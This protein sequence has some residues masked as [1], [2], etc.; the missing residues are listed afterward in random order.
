MSNII[1]A[2]IAVVNDSNHMLV[3][4]SGAHNRINQTGVALE[5]YIIDLFA[6][7]VGE[8]NDIIR[9]KKVSETFSYIGN[10]NNPPDSM[11]KGGGA[12]IEVKKIESSNSNLAL[13]SSYPKAKLYHDSTMI[14]KHCKNCEYWTIR[15]IIYAVGVVKNNIISSIAFVY[16]EDMCADKETYEKIQ[17][18]IK[19][20]IEQIPDIELAETKELGRV[21]R[22]DPLGITYFRIRGMWHIENP[23]KVF[24]YIYKPDNS[25][26]FNLMA[27]ISDDKIATMTNYSQ[28]ESLAISNPTLNI[29]NAEIKNPNNPCQLRKVKLISFSA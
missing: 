13:N 5:K 18:V 26:R 15:D 29:S 16:G 7:T 25:K 21:N 12:A 20:G 9:N 11:L 22:V 27:I 14:N 24:E 4:Q 28:L 3:E 19:T 6:G 2:I 23:F 1:D 10:Q 17:H 8:R